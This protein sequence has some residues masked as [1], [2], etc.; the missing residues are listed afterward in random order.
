MN[1]I[2]TVHKSLATEIEQINQLIIS[3]L[4][5]KEELVEL[6]GR[7]LIESGG[8]RI[9]P[10]LTILTSKMFHYEGRGSIM[11]AAAVEFIHTATLL[12]DDV[13]DD[14]CLRRFKPTANTIWGNK[15]SILVGDFLFSQSFKLMVGAECMPALQALSR[16][17][18]IIAAGEVA[19]LSKLKQR[20]ILSINEYNEIITAKTAELFGAACEVGAII[21]GREQQTCA[22]MHQFGLY[23]GTIFQIMDDWLDYS[24]MDSEAGK[25]IGGDF[26]EGKVTLPLILLY[27]KLCKAEQENL[28]LI[29]KADVRTEQDLQNIRQLLDHHE[30]KQQTMTYL[31]GI[32]AK[33][34]TLLKANGTQNA[35]QRY[36]LALL[37]FAMIRS[38]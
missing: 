24:V 35:Y 7:Y 27:D 32:A 14:S 13:V 25:N 21:A 26:Y 4:E 10:L 1:I 33:A 23:L 34:N 16:A 37:E 22:M 6:V 28:A 38:Y 9:R 31:M 30:I 15:T 8:K 29:I 18:A 36:L 20:R 17:A 11:L 3:H 2:A 5:C 12:H 19:Q